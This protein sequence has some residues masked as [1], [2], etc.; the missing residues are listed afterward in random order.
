MERQELPVL[1][2]SLLHEI[3]A[4]HLTSVL[5]CPWVC[6]SAHHGHLLYS[7][8]VLLLGSCLKSKEIH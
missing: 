6:A 7:E 2:S 1:S 8:W 3:I 5:P 4:R